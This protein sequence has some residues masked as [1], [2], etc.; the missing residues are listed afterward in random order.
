MI[1]RISADIRY[2]TGNLK[3]MTIPA[4]YHVTTE[5]R[6]EADRIQNWLQKVSRELDFVRCCVTGNRYVITG[7]IS[8][9][10]S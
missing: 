2:T 6:S 7:N 4:G 3:G 10:I 5:S 1:Y 8:R 9:D